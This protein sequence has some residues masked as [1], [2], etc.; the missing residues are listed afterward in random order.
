[1]GASGAEVI[2]PDVFDDQLLE[3]PL[4]EVTEE[5]LE[6]AEVVDAEIVEETDAPAKWQD[7]KAK[8]TAQTGAVAQPVMTPAKLAKAEQLENQGLPRTEIARRLG[9]SRSTLYRHLADRKAARAAA[10]ARQKA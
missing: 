9:V 4:A 3:D 5:E 6:E 1:V 2:S 8:A 7:A 10:K